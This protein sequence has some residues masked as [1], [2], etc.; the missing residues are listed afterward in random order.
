MAEVF[1]HNGAG[2]TSVAEV[3]AARDLVPSDRDSTNVARVELDQ[4]DNVRSA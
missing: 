4:T 2:Y 1:A 3:V